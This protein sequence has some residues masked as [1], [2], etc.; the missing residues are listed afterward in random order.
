M[1]KDR[2]TNKG[3]GLAFLVHK[4]VNFNLVKE[5]AILDQD[6]HLETLTINIPGKEQDLFIR[7]VY[8]PPQSSCG[9]NYTPPLNHIHDGL[10]DSYYILGD[11]NA[12]HDLWFSEANPDPRGRLLADTISGQVYG[13]LNE[14][15]PTRVTNQSSTAPDISLAS[16]N[17]IPTTTWKVENKLSSDHL[18]ISISLS[19]DVKRFNSKH[20]TFI[21]FSKANWP[22]F[23]EFTE[24]IFSSARNVTN[25]VQAEKF[26]RNALLRASRKCIPAGRIPKTLN[27]LP[28]EVA[29]LIEIRDDIKKNNPGDARLNDLNNNINQKIKDHRKQKWTEHLDNCPPGSRKLWSTI[30][31]LNDQPPQPDNQGIIFNN[32]PI[33]HPKKL[34]TH[35][36]KQYTPNTN[37]K[38]QQALRKILR[39]MK[40]KP[41]DPAPVFTPSQTLEAIKKA[42]NSKALGPDGLSPIMLKHLGPKGIQYLTN[43]FNECVKSSQIPTIWKTA[44]IIPLLKPGKPSNQGQSY[45]PVS[46]LSP[47]VKTLEALLLP[48]INN[49]V[50]LAE[51]QHGFRKNR[52]TT[53]ALHS[54]LEH[55][56]TGLN[57]KKPVHRTVSVAID[58]S[59]AFDTVDHQLLLEDINNLDLNDHVKRFLCAYLRGRQ[60]YVVFRNSKSTYRKVKQGVPQGGV[61]SPVLFNLYMASMPTPPGNI[62]LVSYADDSNILNSGPLIDKV[63]EEIN[64][65]LSTLDTWFKSRNLHI[66]PSKSSATLFTTASYEVN[67]TLNIHIN[68]DAV[69]TVKKPKFLGVT[70]DGLLSFNQHASD[71][72]TKLQSKNNI[73]KALAGTNWGKEKEVITNTYKAIGQST[74]N[75]CAPIW[76][77]SLSETNWKRLQTAQNSALR[78]ATGCHLMSD[79]DHLHHE[80]KIMKVRPHCE[81]LS[82]QY[83]LATQKQDHPN[84]V[85]LNGRPP[86]RQMK[87]TLQSKFGNYVKSISH[88]NLSSEDYKRKLKTIHTKSVKDMLNSM[89]DNKVLTAPPPPISDSEK[90]LPRAARTTL[91]QLRS[92]YSSFLNSYKARIDNTNSTPDNCP[93]CPAPHTTE[94]L[95]NCPGKPT[96]LTTRD[97]WTAPTEVARFLN[98]VNDDDE[99]NE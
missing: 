83:L 77:P 48:L 64:V 11:V 26:F 56:N 58:L 51:H 69:P 44:K 13:V 63:V 31:S 38:P 84:P 16:P 9:Q 53:T 92:G 47:A 54:I 80:T 41:K 39:S 19:I 90:D 2:G 86:P 75:Y 28:S 33:N 36:N 78:I 46:L 81:M 23:T 20:F 65:Y 71:M 34:A 67:E 88:P 79:V 94:H 42:K 5:P 24:N 59:K 35:F 72:K 82:K 62:K 22:E 87:D 99:M 7:N 27:A 3:G 95:F 57:R 76:T 21:N 15:Q 61:L 18:P 97:L 40:R 6:P 70:F 1:R 52:S 89:A 32:K 68:G 74:L 10:G 25:V 73:L 55:I 45:R 14:D 8:I 12:H 98:L 85:E 66:S 29:R 4:D 50:R 37:K 93:L 30:K 17:L 60:T 91:A 96:D 49:A 43:I